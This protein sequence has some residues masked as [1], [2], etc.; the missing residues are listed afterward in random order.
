MLNILPHVRGLLPSNRAASTKGQPQA[1]G[2]W[3]RKLPVALKRDNC[4]F[5]VSVLLLWLVGFLLLFFI[6]FSAFPTHQDYQKKKILAS[7]FQAWNP[8]AK[9]LHTFMLFPCYNFSD[10]GLWGLRVCTVLKV[11]KRNAK[12]PSRE[13]ETLYPLPSQG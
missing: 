7:Q 5:F 4:F 1:P 3:E 12:L 11:L 2:L 9:I 10:V 13:T 8:K 6:L